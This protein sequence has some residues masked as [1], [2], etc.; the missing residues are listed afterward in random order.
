[1]KIFYHFEQVIRS[2]PKK[3]KTESDAMDKA[4]E[5][6]SKVAEEEEKELESSHLAQNKARI[7]QIPGFQTFNL[8]LS[9]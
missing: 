5:E 3:R 1:M 8:F 4:V 6:F 9:I 2:P 7:T